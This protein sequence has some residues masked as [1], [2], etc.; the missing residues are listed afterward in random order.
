MDSEDTVIGGRYRLLRRL[1]SGGMAEVWLA[2]D[3]RLDNKQVA[4][5]RLLGYR[6]ATPRPRSISSAPAA[7]RSRPH[8]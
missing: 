1:G 2:A 6:P 7:R 4:V 3:L 8:G 5:K